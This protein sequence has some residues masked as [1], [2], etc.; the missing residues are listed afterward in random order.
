MRVVLEWVDSGLLYGVRTRA[1]M[2]SHFMNLRNIDSHFEGTFLP[3]I[4]VFLAWLIKF[5]KNH[6]KGRKFFIF[7][8]P[9]STFQSTK[10]L[11]LH[12]PTPV[13]C[14]FSIKT[15]LRYNIPIFHCHSTRSKA[16]NTH[17]KAKLLYNPI[18]M[19]FKGTTRGLTYSLFKKSLFQTFFY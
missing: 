6:Q 8:G 13:Q 9:K 18:Q 19:A 10:T 7:I 12:Q 14:N 3:P 15:C 1:W 16:R 17:R 11:K 5:S 2:A 4:S